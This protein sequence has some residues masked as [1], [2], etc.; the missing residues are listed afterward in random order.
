LV[1]ETSVVSFRERLDGTYKARFSYK[2]LNILYADHEL[3]FKY[4]FSQDCGLDQELVSINM[5]FQKK[6]SEENISFWDI[7]MGIYPWWISVH[8]WILKYMPNK[9]E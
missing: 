4:F 6:Y 8:H 2:N 3:K 1:P 9:N 5:I 7:L